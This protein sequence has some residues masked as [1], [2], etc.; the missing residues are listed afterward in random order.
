ML[1]AMINRNFFLR[2]LLAAAIFLLI[3]KPFSLVYMHFIVFLSEVISSIFYPYMDIR[4]ID[5][6]TKFQYNNITTQQL[7]F[8]VNDIDQIFLNLIVFLSLMFGSFRVSLRKKIKHII[9]GV[10]ILAAIHLFVTNMYVYTTIWDYVLS[11]PDDLKT[12]LILRV[13][14]Y[15]SQEMTGL[16]RKFLFNW[17]SW[18]WDV[19]PL[20]L[21][22]PS[23]IVQ[24]KYL[25]N[26]D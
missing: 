22:L 19:I 12:E 15:F 18:G 5:G 11:Q 1:P 17:N 24:F 3:W 10:S 13:N 25:V 26:K 4:I 7:Q 2:F 21:W 14:G 8:S 23:G 16:Y 6:I 20:L 9:I